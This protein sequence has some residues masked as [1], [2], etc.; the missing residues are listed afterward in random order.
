MIFRLALAEEFA[1]FRREIEDTLAAAETG[2]LE[3]VGHI[4]RAHISMSFARIR[5]YAEDAVALDFALAGAAF[6]HEA[7]HIRAQPPCHAAT[8]LRHPAPG[9]GFI[10]LGGRTMYRWRAV[11]APG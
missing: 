2:D 6:G 10:S 1:N 11:G 4:R 9:R 3:P 5:R 7:S 8:A